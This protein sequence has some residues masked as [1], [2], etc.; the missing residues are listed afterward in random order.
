M[1][2]IL[3]IQ[4]WKAEKTLA[5]QILEQEGLPKR[6]DCGFVR[7]NNFPWFYKDHIE[8]RGYKSSMDL[9]LHD[10]CFDTNEERDEYLQMI[11]NA[12]TDELFVREDEL[13]IGDLCEVSDEFN[14]SSCYIGEIISILPRGLKQRY[15]I[16]SDWGE[17]GWV[18][19]EY[20]R[21]IH[22]KFKVKECGQLATYTWEE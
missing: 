22:S 2:K 17:K 9:N 3:K 6:K 13:K 15:I 8:L 16:R 11:V 4:F 18:A 12:I 20:A 14:F 5:M 21:K 1:K 19:C 7:I 10:I